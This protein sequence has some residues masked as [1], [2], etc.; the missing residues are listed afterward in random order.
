MQSGLQEITKI[1]ARR[2][3]PQEMVG[4]IHS[5][6]SWTSFIQSEN[7]SKQGGTREISWKKVQCYDAKPMFSST[8]VSP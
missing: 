8:H 6:V 1:M 4:R 5:Q 7:K 2:P 3:H